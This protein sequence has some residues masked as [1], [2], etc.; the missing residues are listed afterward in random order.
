M[1]MYLLDT[2]VYPIRYNHMLAVLPVLGN[3]VPENEYCVIPAS[4]YRAKLIF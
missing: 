4:G 2:E 1:E 3:S